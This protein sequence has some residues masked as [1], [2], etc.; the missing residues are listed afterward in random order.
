MGAAMTAR[1]VAA[2]PRVAYVNA[3]L[4]DPSSG[5]DQPGGL[6]TEG[7][8]IADF[9]PH[10]RADAAPGDA[11]VVDC[12]GFCLAPGLV[13]IRVQ[14]REPG[15]EHKGT[16]A[17]A[18]RAATAGGITSMVCLPNTKPVIYDGSVVQ[19]VVRPARTRG[20]TE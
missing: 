15:E 17:S 20:P 14:L 5:L 1:S 12:G 9:G 8:R 10:L 16:L 2:G 3:R 18:G 7:E 4:L 19:R 11:E 13:D 6:L